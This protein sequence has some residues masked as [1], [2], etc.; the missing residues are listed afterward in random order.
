M[1]LDAALALLAV[2]PTAP[3][4]LAEISL[5][6]AT[7]EYPDLDVDAYLSEV[8]GMAHEARA[9]LRGDLEARVA[10]LCRYLFHDMGFRGNAQDYYDPGNSYLNQVLDRRTGIPIT[11]S[12]LAMAIGGRV[13]IDIQGIGL[14]GHFV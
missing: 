9:Y 2:D 1:D 8:A 3:L 10:G 11:L 12:A 13:G 6:L 14:P 5:R 7:D 4:D